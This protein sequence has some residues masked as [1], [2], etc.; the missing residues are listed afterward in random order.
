MS[1]KPVIRW[2]FRRLEALPGGTI[3]PL[4]LLGPSWRGPYS[5]PTTQRK[6]SHRKIKRGASPCLCLF[7]LFF[8]LSFVF[9]LSFFLSFL[10]F[11][12][13]L[14]VLRPFQGYFSSYETGQSVGVTKTGEHWRIRKQNG[15]SH[16]WP[17]RGSNLHQTQR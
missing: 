12:L 8:F 15:L 2:S 10:S 5:H 13:F 3:S 9:F 6:A 1:G 11:F 14:E 16:M 17:V 4:L 7:T